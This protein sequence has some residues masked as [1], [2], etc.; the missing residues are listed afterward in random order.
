[1]MAPNGSREETGLSE[2]ISR[3]GSTSVH[4]R[5]DPKRRAKSPTP[6]HD[7][8]RWVS[9]FFNFPIKILS[10]RSSRPRMPAE[11]STFAK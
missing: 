7:L 1:M 5:I 3:H 9:L 4:C 10:E 6:N 2:I 8:N 11:E